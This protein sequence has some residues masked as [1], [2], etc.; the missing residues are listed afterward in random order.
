MIVA[1]DDTGWSAN[2]ANAHVEGWVDEN[3]DLD[4][5]RLVARAGER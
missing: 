3:G 1:Y 4:P 2:A 5:D